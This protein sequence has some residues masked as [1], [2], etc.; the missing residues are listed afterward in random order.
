MLKIVLV[1]HKDPYESMVF[2]TYLNILQFYS[3]FIFLFCFILFCLIIEIHRNPSSSSTSSESNIRPITTARKKEPSTARI[4][5]LNGITIKHAHTYHTN[6]YIWPWCGRRVYTREKIH[7][8]VFWDPG[9]LMLTLFFP[10][11]SKQSENKREKNFVLLSIDYLGSI[12]SIVVVV[13]S[14][15][16]RQTFFLAVYLC[17]RLPSLFILLL[18]LLLS[19]FEMKPELSLFSKL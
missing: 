16:N 9:C 6:I 1:P 7:S 2:G 18:L 15:R 4:L 5:G 12:F 3:L 14:N 8:L 17:K 11:N 19:L 13:E 10:N